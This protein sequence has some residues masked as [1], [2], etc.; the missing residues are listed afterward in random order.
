MVGPPY[1]VAA[2]V[3]LLAAQYWTDIDGEA[4]MKGVNLFH[5]RLD[6]FI[7]AVLY[8]VLGKVEDREKFWWQLEQP[9]PGRVRQADVNR[10][11]D[12]FAA[13]VGKVG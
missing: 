3:F 10:E 4:A 9:M 5:L 7:N 6:R 2:R 12:D 13:L 1:V 8:W 11:L